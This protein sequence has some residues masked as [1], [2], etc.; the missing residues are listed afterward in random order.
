[1][2]SIKTKNSFFILLLSLLTIVSCRSKEE[3]KKMF[4]T[5]GP[6][7]LNTIR[8]HLPQKMVRWDSTGFEPEINAQYF[9][10]LTF[11]ESG[12]V[13]VKRYLDVPERPGGHYYYDK[14]KWVYNDE[15]E[16]LMLELGGAHK[17]DDAGIKYKAE[18]QIDKLSAD[19]LRVTR[20]RVIT[21]E[22][23]FRDH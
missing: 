11:S 10:T 22:G 15:M 14:G 17:K 5:G 18:Y 20:I 1:M 12:D 13:E 4:L 19:T 8:T 9:E 23:D 7:K 21:K 16:V 3:E 6:W 2:S